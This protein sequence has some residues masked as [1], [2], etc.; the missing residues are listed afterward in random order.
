MVATDPMHQ[1]QITRLLPF[2]VGDLDL[3]FTNSALFMAIAVIGILGFLAFATSKLQTVPGRA[4]SL[5]EIWYT[6][7]AGIV[8]DVNHDDG[9]PYI[10]LVFS[11]FSFI[12]VAN[13]LGMFPYFF[14]TTSHVAVTF[15]MALFT[16]GLVVVI[17]VWKNG[18]SFLKIFTPSGVPLYILWFV[19]IIEIFSFLS[20]PLSFGMRLFANMLAGHVALK[21]FAGF[22]P[23]LAVGLGAIGV[24]MGG[25]LVLPLVVGITALE[26]LVAFLQAYVFAILTCVYLNDALHPG[27]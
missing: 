14:T 7:V 2:E 13:L 11:L 6:F 17:G 23:T 20:R 22:I 12:L 21:I 27:H 9:K 8:H 5:A 18:F 24:A 3:S 16:I 1:F 26:F 15:T 4:Q 25:L 10:P 19:V